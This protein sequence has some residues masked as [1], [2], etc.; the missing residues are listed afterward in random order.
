MLPIH[1]IPNEVDCILPALANYL[2]YDYNACSKG[3][4]AIGH[5]MASI[6]V[7]LA[8]FR[9]HCRYSSQDSYWSIYANL[10]RTNFLFLCMVLL[11][12]HV[13]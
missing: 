8:P 9:F 4:N 5:T 3:C 1:A 6:G 12:D 2:L 7:Q 11:S 10:A 13:L